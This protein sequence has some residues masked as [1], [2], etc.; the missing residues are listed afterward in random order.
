MHSAALLRD[1]D[2]M[3]EAGV[4]STTPGE[5][6]IR[7]DVVLLVGGGLS[8][9]GLWRGFGRICARGSLAPPASMGASAPDNIARP[10]WGLPVGAGGRREQRRRRVAGRW[11][12]RRGALPE[13]LG[14]LH[15]RGSTADPPRFRRTGCARSTRSPPRCFPP[16]SGGRVVGGA[17]GRAY[18]R[19]ALRP[20]QGLERED[21]LHRALPLAPGRRTRP[22]FSRF[23][24]G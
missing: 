19:N 9:A 6:R 2:V 22:A 14:A 11:A 24:V 10:G 16:H 5:A 15:A 1:L 18:D 12:R 4:M 20:R 23:A 13:L 8:E 17:V 21:A 3:R 7:G